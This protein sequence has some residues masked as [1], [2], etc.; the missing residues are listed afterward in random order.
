[1]SIDNLFSFWVVA[2]LLSF[3]LEAAAVVV[4]AL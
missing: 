4:V 2:V 1:M 3:P